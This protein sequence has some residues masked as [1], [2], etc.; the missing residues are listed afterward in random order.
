[1]CTPSC[2][3]GFGNC[4]NNA[5]NGCET[6]L[7]TDPAHCGSCTN[8][9]SSANGTPSC[10]STG[11]SIG[12]F[13]GFGNCDGQ[14][15]NGCETNLNTSASNCGTCGYAC[16]GTNGVATCALGGCSLTCNP[17][18]GN[19]DGNAQGNGCEVN[20]LTDPKNCGT[21][22]KV[23]AGNCNNGTC[24]ATSVV[25]DI[26]PPTGWLN[27]PGNAGGW[28]AK[29]YVATF[30]TAT[31]ITAF[32]LKCTLPSSLSIRAQIWDTATQVKLATGTP[33]FG[34]GTQQWYRS[35]IAF[36]PTAGKS[37]TI[38]FFLSST[39]VLP[40]KDGPTLPYTVGNI[41][42]TRSM[43]TYDQTSDS[44]PSVD[45]S[46]ALFMRVVEN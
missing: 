44:Y 13:S 43:S 21:C 4:D 41:T 12:C 35:P 39:I 20:L 32:D 24:A 17:G 5:N 42:V 29:Y 25:V 26:T 30:N 3:T 6:S 10:S 36:T 15:N 40:Y 23:C 18:Y 2:N 46:W 16:N 38:G 7:T 11:C 34:N 19:C 27:D 9:C 1:V 33:V 14:I 37:Y 8:V 45:N 28:S 22:G 31:P